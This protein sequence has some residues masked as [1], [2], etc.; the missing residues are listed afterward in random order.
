M[1]QTENQTFLVREAKSKSD[2]DCRLRLD[3]GMEEIQNLRK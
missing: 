2:V 3:M 1:Q